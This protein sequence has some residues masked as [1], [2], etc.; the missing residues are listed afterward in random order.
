[1]L[2][3]VEGDAAAFVKPDE[4]AAPSIQKSAPNDPTLFDGFEA[5]G[6][7]AATKDVEVQFVKWMRPSEPNDQSTDISVEMICSLPRRRALYFRE[8]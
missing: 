4:G 2:H 1:M 8:S 3:I 7:V 5:L 6:T